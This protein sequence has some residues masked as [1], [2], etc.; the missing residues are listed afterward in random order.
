MRSVMGSRGSLKV[1]DRPGLGCYVAVIEREK[2]GAQVIDLLRY[3][4]TPCDLHELHRYA[5]EVQDV[6]DRG[7]EARRSRR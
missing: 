1:Y 4:R 6:V 3:P 7:R 2:N 5:D